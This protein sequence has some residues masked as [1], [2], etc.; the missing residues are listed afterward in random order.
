MERQRGRERDGK[1][2]QTDR[3]L[4]VP[5]KGNTHFQKLPSPDMGCKIKTWS[6]GQLQVLG[7]MVGH[8]LPKHHQLV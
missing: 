4:W 3:A 6:G 7:Y 5:V 1:R 2:E 8:R